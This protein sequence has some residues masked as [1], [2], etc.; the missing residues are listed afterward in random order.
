METRGLE[1]STFALRTRRHRT[2][3][4]QTQA[5]TS[6]SANACTNACTNFAESE[7][8]DSSDGAGA[9]GAGAGVDTF[10]DV[11]RMLDRLPLTDAERAEAVRRL[12]DPTAKVKP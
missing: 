2:E 5:L 9:G 4:T 10:A 6:T 1:P 7:H 3:G 12:L 8:A 11:L